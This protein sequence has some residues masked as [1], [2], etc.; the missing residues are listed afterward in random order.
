MNSSINGI[1]SSLKIFKESTEIR[2]KKKQRFLIIKFILIFFISHGL[3]SILMNKPI[4][5]PAP[6]K[7]VKEN[8][9][10]MKIKAQSFVSEDATRANLF[11]KIKH[12]E[13]ENI[14]IIALKADSDF[15]EIEIPVDKVGLILMNQE[16]WQLIPQRKAKK[17]KKEKRYEILL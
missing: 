6:Q 2:N 12:I 7:Q 16:N 3:R 13:I 5:V 8:F 15:F 9:L 14:E 1:D 4:S 10:R 17:N 11:H